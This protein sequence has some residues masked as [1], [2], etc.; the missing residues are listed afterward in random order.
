M[1]DQN[2]IKEQ[3]RERYAREANRVRQSSSASSCCSSTATKRA[4]PITTNRA[5]KPSVA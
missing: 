5:S 3:V 4:D 2:S 1:E